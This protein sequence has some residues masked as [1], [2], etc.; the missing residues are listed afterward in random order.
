[1]KNG[2][3]KIATLGALHP[4]YYSEHMKCYTLQL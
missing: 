1:M 3:Y 4:G 2:S